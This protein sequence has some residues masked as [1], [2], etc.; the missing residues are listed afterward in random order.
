MC[1]V[2]YLFLNHLQK[3]EFFTHL[4]SMI[5]KNDLFKHIFDNLEEAVIIFKDGEVTYANDMFLAKFRTLISR[6]SV[7]EV[8]DVFETKKRCCSKTARKTKFDSSFFT[9]ALFGEYA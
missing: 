5:D 1:F 4:K 8:K 3:N 7:V 6:A 9:E 2:I